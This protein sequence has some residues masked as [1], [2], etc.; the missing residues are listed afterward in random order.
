MPMGS[1]SVSYGAGA[2]ALSELVPRRR[3]RAAGR[4]T[5]RPSHH[6]RATVIDVDLPPAPAFS[7]PTESFPRGRLP[8]RP[9]HVLL[10]SM[11]LL[12]IIRQCPIELCHLRE[13]QEKGNTPRSHYAF[14]SVGFPTQQHHHHH[15]TLA[16]SSWLLPFAVHDKNE[17]CSTGDSLLV[18]Q[19]GL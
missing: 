1:V 10:S 2:G 17:V 4:G 7:Q 14:R 11:C 9:L 13:V 16:V 6:H 12:T 15:L 3:P 5:F 8:L 18:K 19:G